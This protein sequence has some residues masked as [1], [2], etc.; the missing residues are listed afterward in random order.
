MKNSLLF[1]TFIASMAILH[2]NT[3]SLVSKNQDIDVYD[4][5]GMN[6]VLKEK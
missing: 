2:G 1:V 6:F 5:K 4:A 3:F